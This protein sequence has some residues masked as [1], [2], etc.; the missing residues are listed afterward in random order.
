MGGFS[1]SFFPVCSVPLFAL[2]RQALTTS[3]QAA[4]LGDNPTKS[5]ISQN[6]EDNKKRSQEF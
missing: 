5:Q 6:V 4:V 3:G 2:S 1:S